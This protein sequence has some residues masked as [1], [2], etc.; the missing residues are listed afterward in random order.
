MKRP[1]PCVFMR[2]GRLLPRPDA[3]HA[4]SHVDAE[5]ALLRDLVLSFTLQNAARVGMMCCAPFQGRV[6]LETAEQRANEEEV[7]E[8]TTTQMYRAPE[9]VDLYLERELTEKVDV[10]VSEKG[11]GLVIWP[12]VP[13]STLGVL[14][15][16]S[17]SFCFFVWSS[18]GLRK[19]KKNYLLLVS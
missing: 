18:G 17:L 5:G 1:R 9:M 7:V 2:G 15:L 16:C 10:W 19:E 6:P 13:L 11:S 4:R 8:K 14:L 3:P 12:C